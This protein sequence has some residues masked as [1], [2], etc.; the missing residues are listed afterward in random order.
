MSTEFS[1]QEGIR[2]ESLNEII[3]AGINPYPAELY[4]INV[5]SEEI[6]KNFPNDKTLYQDISIAGRLM[7]RRIMGAASFCELQDSSGKI[8]LYIKRDDICPTEDKT[9]YNTIFKK[10]LDIGDIIGIKGYVFSHKWGK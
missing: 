4:E 2:R 3:K 9:L 5:S 8:Q 10:H 1:E 7:Q 6:L